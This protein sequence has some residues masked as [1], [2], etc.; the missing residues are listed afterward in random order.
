MSLAACWRYLALLLVPSLF[1]G[2]LPSRAYAD[3]LT[4][5]NTIARTGLNGSETLLT[6]AAV[7]SNQFGL[8]KNVLVDG[9]VDAQPLY[10]SA[11][12]VNGATHNLLFVATEH[13]SLYAIDADS[14]TIY[15]QTSMLA[16]G[17]T[18]SDSRGCGQIVP[19]IGIT[20]T[21]AIDRAA[22]PNGTLFLVAMSKNA[23]GSYFQRIHAI[24]LSTGAERSG[25]PRA[26][27]ASFPGTGDNSA[28]GTVV[29]DPKQYVARPA[30]LLRDGMV[31]TSW[32]S[33]CDIRP[34]SGWVIA[35]S[36][37]TLGRSAVFN[38]APNGSE[39]ALWNAGAGP[40]ADTIGNIYVA[41][42]NGTFDTVLNAQGLPS[43][44]DYGNAMLKMHDLTLTPLDY[45]TM[46]NSTAESNADVDLG[47][48]G[49][50]LLPDQRDASG[51]V[52]HLAVAAGKDTNLY[53]TNRDA[54]GHY[55]AAN[56][57]T[58]YQQLS[59]VL[60]GGV[61]S[62]PAYF[63]G[64]VYYGSVGSSLRSFPIT[65]A[66]LQGTGIQTT[67][68]VFPYPG[69]TPSISASGSSNGILWA[70]T[71]ASPAVLHA[72]DAANL[73]TEL[74]NSAQAGTRDQFG[75]GNKF[76]TPT[77]ANGKVYVGTT[78]GVAIFG[79][80]PL[81]AA[82]VTDGDYVLKNAHSQ[83]VLDSP[84]GSANSGSAMSQSQADQGL[85]QSWFVS[86]NGDGYYT[87]QN[88]S[89]ELFLTDP[90]S[91]A[92]EGLSL[93]QASATHDDSQLWSLQPSGG[94]YA[95]ANRATGLV[96]DDRGL[97]LAEG[98]HII[99]WRP[100]GG[101]NQTWTLE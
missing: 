71:N 65:A 44:G 6:P 20:S 37:T 54:M 70:T 53:L 78:N 11:L 84:S 29:F 99:L 22:G 66:R 12:R 35:Y 89:S 26:V 96:L 5:H 3:V 9:K 40:A 100:N 10:V 79:F 88:V 98:S 81:I 63:N 75:V 82:I 52:W 50:M 93:E 47:S 60:P 38:A 30:L 67:T 59:G 2:A 48:G 8:L 36:V 28:N 21:P 74:Y 86:Y 14:G 87:I 32:G 64:R 97:T 85:S 31:F 56:D 17:E 101:S 69:A 41:L 57:G 33:H 72:Y 68:T 46:Y 4:W 51:K 80:I 58:I 77:V 49:L 23:A 91:S 16:A 34:Y 19:E 92:T 73:G 7:N 83:L 76:I 55:D 90:N 43:K 15:W 42:A 27:Q 1:A 39:G 24:D 18:T 94:G 62:S 95:I 61:W 45:W 25:G 13:D